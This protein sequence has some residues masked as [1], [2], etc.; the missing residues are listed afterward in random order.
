MKNMQLDQDDI[1]K[2]I[3]VVMGESD[4]EFDKRLD[5][6]HQQID[7]IREQ[8]STISDVRLALR[9]DILEA[10]TG[11]L[12]EDRLDLDEAL[13][14][15]SKRFGRLS[16]AIEERLAEMRDGE[17]GPPGERGE[18]GPEGRAGLSFTI[19]GTWI[20]INEYRALDVV[21]LG[22]ASF[23]ARHDDPGPCPGDGWQL[24]AAQ[25]KRGNAG[26][27]GSPGVKGDRGEPGLPVVAM[28]IND[29]GMLTLVNGDGSTVA[30]DL[31]PLLTKVA[32]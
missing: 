23:A 16:V 7:R 19:R 26:E 14:A 12:R 4:R 2:A 22:G 8:E 28:S 5:T 13:F 29:E 31:Y 10:V 11:K 6:L 17:P 32:R 25:G 21:A 1:L 20:E 9:E 15:A 27:R 24:I 3:G 18:P 30:C